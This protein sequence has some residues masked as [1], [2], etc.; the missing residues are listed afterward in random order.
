ML[1]AVILTPRLLSLCPSPSQAPQRRQLVL[2]VP[3]RRLFSVSRLTI[4]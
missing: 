2:D 3:N 1:V 4:Y